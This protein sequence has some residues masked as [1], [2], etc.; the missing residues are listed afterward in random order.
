VHNLDAELKELTATIQAGVALRERRSKSNIKS[1]LTVTLAGIL[2]TFVCLWVFLHNMIAPHIA[3]HTPLPSLVL[4][5]LL[6]LLALLSLGPFGA[7]GRLG[8]LQQDRSTAKEHDAASR[9]AEIDDVRAVG[10][11][12]DALIL[13]W[14]HKGG[15]R[16]ALWQA[17]G[18]LLPRLS[19]DEARALGQERHYFLANWV[20]SWDV[21]AH[22][23]PFAESDSQTLV[24]ILHT[25]AQIGKS[26]FQ[27]PQ[28]RMA[29]VNLLPNLN[30]WAEGKGAGQ[31]PAVQQAA[32]AC[33]EEIEQKMALARSGAH[34]LRASAPT[35]AGSDTLLRSA[36]GTHPTDPQELLRP[37]NSDR[38]S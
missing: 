5:L 32:I 20:R 15:L 19:E 12:I 27:Y 2:A 11:I 31:D 36:H 37:E 21:P 38:A 22:S 13:V 17:L 3:S 1:I 8:W 30:R 14:L 35:P 28:I 25:M 6:S 34:L 33:R 4:P 26:S 29:N 10:P 24:A 16:P 9:I 7:L 23:E 18:R